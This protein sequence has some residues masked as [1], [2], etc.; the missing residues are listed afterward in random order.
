M[1]KK[2]TWQ[3]QKTTI[4]EKDTEVSVSPEDQVLYEMLQKLGKGM[5]RSGGGSW[6]IGQKD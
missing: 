6:I 1:R 2:N 4:P 3:K 5:K